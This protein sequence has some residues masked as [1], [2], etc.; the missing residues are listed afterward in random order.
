MV[1]RRDRSCLRLRT[2]ETSENGLTSEFS[3]S[4]VHGG[5]LTLGS[6]NVFLVS[7][8]LHQ[9]REAAPAQDSTEARHRL[10]KYVRSITPSSKL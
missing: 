9:R 7:N 3:P 8:E 4:S 2:R 10:R 6:R 5:G 1:T